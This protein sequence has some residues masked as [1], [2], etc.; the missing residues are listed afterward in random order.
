MFFSLDSSNFNFLFHISKNYHLSAPFWN[1]ETEMFQNLFLAIGNCLS[2]LVLGVLKK[3]G[4]SNWIISP[5]F[6]FLRTCYFDFFSLEIV[7]LLLPSVCWRNVG[8]Q[9]GSC[10]CQHHHF[11]PTSVQY[12]IWDGKEMY[13]GT[14]VAY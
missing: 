1:S 11:S 3:C 7:C 4:R 5:V 9:I 6:N 13:D 10:C 14:D 8:G 2:S 12:L